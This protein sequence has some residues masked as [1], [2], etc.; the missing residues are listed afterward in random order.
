M[1]RKERRQVVSK[2]EIRNPFN[3]MPEI[4]LKE[5]GSC[6]HPTPADKTA[7]GYDLYVAENTYIEP[8]KRTIVKTHV[9][10][11]LPRNVEGKVEPRSGFSVKGMEGLGTKK[12]WILKWG[13]LPWR[14]TESGKLRFNAD[15]INGKIDPGYK[16]DIGVIVKNDDVGF[17]VTAGTRIAQ[18]T[19]Y[20]VLRPHFKVV[21]ELS[22]E[23]R[24]GGFG[25]T[26]TTDKK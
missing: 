13:F 19:F 14:I 2:T 9:S 15:V 7:I 11:N 24:G 4:E 5:L 10:L 20:R 3:W 6:K 18:L 1:E 22:C 8:H 12:R 21:E 25:H 16:G 26:G 17:T 23:D